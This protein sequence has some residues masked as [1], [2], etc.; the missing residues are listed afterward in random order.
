MKL[1]ELN[2]YKSADEISDTIW[3]IVETWDYYKKD[4]LGK[5]LVRAA[6]SI[7]ANIAEGYGRF[8]F[9]E[10]RNFCYYSRGSLLETK[11]WLGKAF[12]RKMISNET[13]N[14]L[15]TDLDSLHKSLNG[16]IKYIT[17][18]ASDKK[19]SKPIS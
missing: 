15:I 14:S 8:F 6:D 16:Y 12:R 10:N 2:I 13:Y 1:E 7:S 4:T 19:P 11:N 17:Q 9:K 18:Q 3:S 5:Q